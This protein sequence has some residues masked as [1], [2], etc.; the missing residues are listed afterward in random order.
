M[1]GL[2]RPGALRLHVHVVIVDGAC[3]VDAVVVLCEPF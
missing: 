1:P 2:K 3:V